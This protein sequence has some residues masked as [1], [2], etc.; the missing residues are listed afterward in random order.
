MGVANSKLAELKNY[1]AEKE[2]KAK[3][4]QIYA[5]KAT[6]LTLLVKAFSID[7]VPFQIV[8]SVVPELSSQANEILSQMTGGKMSIEMKMDKILKNKS[9]VNALEIWISDYQRGTMPYLSRSGGQKVKAALSV[10]FSLADL[11]ANRAGIQLGMMFIDEPPF[12]D[13]DGV[14]AYCDALEL[15]HNRYPSMRVVAISHDPA[16]KARFPQE[17]EVI[18]TGDSGSKIIFN[19]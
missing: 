14:Q 13:G 12:L 2:E 8:R 1:D 15:I 18:D 17:I 19:S 11:K 10:A 9:E 7:G 3:A 4:L 6:N 5:S 16:M